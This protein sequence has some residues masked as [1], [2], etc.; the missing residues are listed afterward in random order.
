MAQISPAPSECPIWLSANTNPITFIH[1]LIIRHRLFLSAAQAWVDL[2]CLQI[3]HGTNYG[4][5]VPYEVALTIL[6]CAESLRLVVT[7]EH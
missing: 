4:L 2:G 6:Q 5:P 3:P 1:P 7:P